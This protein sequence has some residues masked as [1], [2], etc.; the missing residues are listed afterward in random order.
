M[1]QEMQRDAA[2]DAKMAASRVAILNGVVEPIEVLG[3]V[4]NNSGY[5][6]VH[7]MKSGKFQ[8]TFMERPGSL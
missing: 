7:Q 1:Q 2:R 8:A 5:Q 4:T 6:F 3:S